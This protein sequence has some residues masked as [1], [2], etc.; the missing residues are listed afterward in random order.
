MPRNPEKILGQTNL[1]QYGWMMAVRK[2]V[3]FTGCR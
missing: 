2:Y 1:H 3:Q